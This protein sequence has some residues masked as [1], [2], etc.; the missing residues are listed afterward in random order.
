LLR[1]LV[2]AV[3]G[4]AGGVDSGAVVC[5]LVVAVFAVTAGAG[6]P[7]PPLA[8]VFDWPLVALAL[9]CVAAASSAAASLAVRR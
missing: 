5:A 7:L 1:A 3:V 4:I 8:L 9:V 6:N 2:V